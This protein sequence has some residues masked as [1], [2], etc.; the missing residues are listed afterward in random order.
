MIK[1]Q[2]YEDIEK[3][4]FEGRPFDDANEVV[5]SVLDEVQKKGDAALRIYGQ[6]FDVSVPGVFEVPQEELKAAAEKLKI[7]KREIY[8]ALVYSH[9]LALKFAQEENLFQILKQN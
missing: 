8:D 4:F 9:T 1:I 2:K 7:N 3:K 6:K 5:L